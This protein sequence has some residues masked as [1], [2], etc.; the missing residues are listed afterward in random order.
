MKGFDEHFSRTFFL[1][2][3]MALILG[4]TAAAG[5]FANKFLLIEAQLPIWLRLPLAVGAAYLA[6]FFLIRIWLA[7]VASVYRPLLGGGDNQ[8]PQ[9]A[10]VENSKSRQWDPGL[11]SLGDIPGDEGGCLIALLLLC[12]LILLGGAVILL[13]EAPIILTEAALQFFLAIGLLR[14][15]KRIDSGQWSGSVL[16]STWKPFFA[17]LLAAA[18]TGGAAALSCPQARTV[19]EALWCR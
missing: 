9:P 1:R 17:I 5:V 13:V 10:S 16:R 11:D 18:L 4:G 14:P 12:L 19:T 2:Y 8:K 3:H 6:F 7:Y 15:F